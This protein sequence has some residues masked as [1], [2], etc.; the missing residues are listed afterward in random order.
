MEKYLHLIHSARPVGSA[1]I[2][3][4]RPAGSAPVARPLGSAPIRLVRPLGSEPHD[5]EGTHVPRSFKIVGSSR[6]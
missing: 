2:R 6:G 5:Q 4:V 1:P 3:L